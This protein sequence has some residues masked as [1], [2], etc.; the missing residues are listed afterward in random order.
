MNAAPLLSAGGLIAITKGYCAA[1]EIEA[2]N[3]LHIQTAGVLAAAHLVSQ[4]GA[5]E[6]LP[7]AVSTGV[8]FSAA[9]WGLGNRN[10]V[11]W[12]VM[13]TV[14]GYVAETLSGGEVNEKTEEDS[15]RPRG[16]DDGGLD[17]SRIYA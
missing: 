7:R 17:Q 16:A 1:N 11:R 8:L 5:R 12:M 2:A 10:A 13:G 4:H 15:D 6:V 14:L 3:S 9:M